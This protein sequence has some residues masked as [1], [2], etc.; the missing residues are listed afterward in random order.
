MPARTCPAA[1][2]WRFALPLSFMSA[3]LIV[4]AATE[5]DRVAKAAFLLSWAL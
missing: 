5:A 3:A 1:T 2:A 4:M